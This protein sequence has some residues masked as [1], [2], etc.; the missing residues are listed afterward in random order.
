MRPSHGRSRGEGR[1]TQLAVLLQG[2]DTARTRVHG[3]WDLGLSF[4]EN[5][6][7]GVWYRAGFQKPGARYLLANG[8]H[9]LQGFH[10]P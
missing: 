8:Q 9:V 5:M 4:E 2:R 3:E 1:P 7:T 10:D 6:R